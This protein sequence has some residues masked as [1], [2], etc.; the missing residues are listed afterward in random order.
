MSMPVMPTGSAPPA[1]ATGR[2][3]ARFVGRP[4]AGRPAAGIAAG[5]AA[6]LLG[7]LVLGVLQGKTGQRGPEVGYWALALG[8]LVGAVLGRFGGRAPLTAYAGVPLALLAVCAAQFVGAAILLA[9][10][11]GSATTA[12]T[13]LRHFGAVAH[14][15]QHDL[16]GK[17]DITFYTVAAAEGFLV[18]RRVAE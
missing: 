18:A 7:A 8:L 14:Y 16:L 4:D 11:A 12:E 5:L 6:A 10:A 17:N 9:D 13:L 1:P 3:R 15:W 2:T